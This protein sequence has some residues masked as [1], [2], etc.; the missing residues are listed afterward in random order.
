MRQ[1]L[2]EFTVEKAR[3]FETF[4]QIPKYSH[5]TLAVIHPSPVKVERK[6]K[7]VPPAT[8]AFDS[9]KA[10]V[11]SRRF[12]Q[13]NIPEHLVRP[14]IDEE[15]L[16]KIKANN[17]MREEAL[18]M[19]KSKQ[20]VSL[21]TQK[22]EQA[23]AKAKSE[24]S[25]KIRRA[26]KNTKLL[27]G[28]LKKILEK[29]SD[30]V[31]FPNQEARVEQ[32]KYAEKNGALV[33]CIYT[34]F[35][36]G[37]SARSVSRQKFIQFVKHFLKDVSDSQ[38]SDIFMHISKKLQAILQNIS[39]PNQSRLDETG[40]GNSDL[41]SV[42]RLSTYGM[43]QTELADLRMDMGIVDGQYQKWADEDD[44]LSGV[45]NVKITKQKN[46]DLKL[47]IEAWRN[48]QNERKGIKKRNYDHGK[49]LR[50]FFK[51]SIETFNLEKERVVACLDNYNTFVEDMKKL[52][53]ENKLI[54]N[55]LSELPNG[56]QVW[57]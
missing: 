32:A 30:D 6:M 20:K 3:E 57:V 56:P 23:A 37:E 47:K 10:T 46:A 50:E 19:G 51:K 34:V 29:P 5:A 43:S 24:L 26:E 22:A 2:L 53:R 4:K 13:K 48:R 16:M 9:T 36:G 54:N 55:F 17:K 11:A 27:F 12:E 1:T 25:I 15:R 28:E 35:S 7:H 41:A 42:V 18:Q 38:C 44:N 52:A 31:I 21:A 33:S 49:A 39:S 8:L 40:G 45:L 14:P